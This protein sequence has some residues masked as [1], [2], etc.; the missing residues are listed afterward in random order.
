MTNPYVITWTVTD[1]HG[2]GLIGLHL[3][4]HLRQLGRDPLLAVAAKDILHE[5]YAQK[6]FPLNASVQMFQDMYAGKPDMRVESDQIDTLHGLGN[7]F[8]ETDE[9]RRL[10]GKR[11]IAMIFFEEQKMTQQVLARAQKFDAIIVGSTYNYDILIEAGL[12]NVHRCFQGIDPY[13]LTPKKPSGRFGEK[14]AIFSGGKLE[15]RKGQDLVLAAFKIFHGRYPDSI[16]V[17]NW[18]NFWPDSAQTINEAPYIE[19]KLEATTQYSMKTWAVANG[20]A[21]DAFVDLEVV[22]RTDLSQIFADVDVAVFPNRCEGGT[23]L[24]CN[25]TMFC[26]VPTILSANTGHLDMMPEGK[27]VCIPL[28]KQTPVND[29][30]GTRAGWCESDVDEIVEALEQV[31]HHREEAKQM[32]RRASAF[33]GKER[34]WQSFAKQCIGLFDGV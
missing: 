2:W 1:R 32:A 29:E 25:E 4:L 3:S 7:N 19:H 20:V 15:Y 22:K 23:N 24:V 30:Q 17:A 9:G 16:L 34:T 11:N 18:V 26:R 31:Y 14:F 12:K 10:W 33:I 27:E 13:E 28:Q 8:L 5:S 21:E 6:I